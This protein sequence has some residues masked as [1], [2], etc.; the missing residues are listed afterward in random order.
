MLADP[1]FCA[2][3]PT[4]SIETNMDGNESWTINFRQGIG[5]GWQ[6][7][8]PDDACEYFLAVLEDRLDVFRA[9]RN[10]SGDYRD[11]AAFRVL[12]DTLRMAFEVL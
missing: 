4:L 5:I 3:P 11:A 8:S 12:R 7:L 2:L 6:G 1:A 10:F 9:V